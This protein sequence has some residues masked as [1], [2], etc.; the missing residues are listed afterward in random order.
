MLI[1]L[2]AYMNRVIIA[3]QREIG[4]LCNYMIICLYA[5]NDRGQED[6][7]EGTG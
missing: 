5:Y 1:S 6:R 2:Y 3:L 7:A 4:V